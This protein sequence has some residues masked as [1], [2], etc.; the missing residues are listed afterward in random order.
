M[1]HE[2]THCTLSKEV[3]KEEEGGEKEEDEEFRT[4]LQVFAD[5]AIP[6]PNLQR[7]P[8]NMYT[9]ADALIIIICQIW[10]SVQSLGLPRPLHGC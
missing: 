10:Y 4:R 7:V 8:L 9:P 3:G 1:I 6:N 5:P 2:R